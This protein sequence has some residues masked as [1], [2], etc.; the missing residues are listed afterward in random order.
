[1]EG[2]L[3]KKDLDMI[4]GIIVENMGDTYLEDDQIIMMADQIKGHIESY[5]QMKE[6][7]C[8]G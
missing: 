5:M 6:A 2:Y 8:D 7:V 4:Y 1:M 3:T